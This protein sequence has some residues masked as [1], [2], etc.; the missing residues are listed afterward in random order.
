LNE[1]GRIRLGL[2]AALVTTYPDDVTV[3]GHHLGTLESGGG[4]AS[5]IFQG[6]PLVKRPKRIH[7]FL[8]RTVQGELKEGA[9][10]CIHI[11][12]QLTA[13]SIDDRLIDR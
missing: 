7:E 2:S 10:R 6:F 13:V 3:P 11:C 9:A 12:P 1:G 5:A 4:R 8:F